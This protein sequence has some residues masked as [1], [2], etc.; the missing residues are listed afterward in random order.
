VLLS[1]DRSPAHLIERLDAIERVMPNA[2]R[3]VLHKLDHGADLKAP[4]EMVRAIDKV[5]DSSR[6]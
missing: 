4:Q 3:V 1:G 2:E 5:R 6:R